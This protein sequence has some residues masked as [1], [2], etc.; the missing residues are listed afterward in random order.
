[1]PHAVEAALQDELR[2]AGLPCRGAPARLLALMRGSQETHLTL[3]EVADLAAEA[4]LALPPAD[5]ARHVEVFADHGLIGRVPTTT[6]EL[7][8]DTVPGPHSHLVYEE[9]EQIVDLHVSPDTLLAMVR[10][11]LNK[12]PEGVEILLRFRRTPAS[13]PAIRIVDER[14]GDDPG[15]DR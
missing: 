11:A 14:S 2:R 6:T 8:F 9:S 5:L 1:M 3:P 7:V 4:G 15:P 13:G 10:D 12:R